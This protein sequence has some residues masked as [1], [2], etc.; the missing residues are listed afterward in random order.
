[1][2]VP[3]DRVSCRADIMSATAD[4]MRAVADLVFPEGFV[5]A[6]DFNQ[7]GAEKLLVIILRLW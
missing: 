3:A 1:M 4:T 5:P 6:S 7:N 2:S